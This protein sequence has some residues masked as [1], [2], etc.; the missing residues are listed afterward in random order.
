MS[1]VVFLLEE[2]SM[3]ELLDGLLPRLVPGLLFQ[4]VPHEGRQDLEIS[5]P[6]K[7][8]GWREPGIQFVVIR[9][10]DQSDCHAL[11]KRLV[12]LCHKGGRTDT[13]VRIP[14]QELESWYIGEP[15]ALASAFDRPDLVNLSRKARFR[16]SDMVVNPSHELEKLV[17]EFQ[18]VSG[19]RR[20]ALHLSAERNRSTSFRCFLAGVRRL[21]R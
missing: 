11:K 5:I 1:R 4:C 6:R 8:R 18:K 17:P 9:D 13:L 12:E 2:R 14:C 21:A 19:A 10:N 20:M 3:Q 15:E 7:L 16:D